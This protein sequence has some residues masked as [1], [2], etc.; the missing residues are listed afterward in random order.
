MTLS[1]TYWSK[2]TNMAS[3]YKGEV[4][5][6][7]NR[8]SP[9]ERTRLRNFVDRNWMRS[10]SPTEYLV[11]IFVFDRTISWGKSSERIT[12]NEFEK[13]RKNTFCGT[14]LSRSTLIRTLKNLVYL[15]T[16]VV[17]GV[18][19][20]PKKYA[21]N[22][23]WRPEENP[24]LPPRKA[25]KRTNVEQK[26]TN[27]TPHR[28]QND[29]QQGVSMTPLISR[30]YKKTN[31]ELERASP[32][33]SL[34]QPKKTVSK[35]SGRAC[36]IKEAI[37]KTE[38]SNAEKI[39]KRVLKARQSDN[40]DDVQKVWAHEFTNQWEDAPVIPWSPKTRGL[41]HHAVK[42]KAF[43]SIDVSE[44]V[45]WVIVDWGLLRETA[46]HWMKDMPLSPDPELFM[47]HIYKFLTA[48]S[49]RI[50][51]RQ[52][53]DVAGSKRMRMRLQ[54]QGLTADQA[55]AK[56]IRNRERV[57]NLQRDEDNLVAREK[58]LL[59]EKAILQRQ[60]RNLQA[61]QNMKGTKPLANNSEPAK[62]ETPQLK[63]LPKLD[64]D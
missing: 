32:S 2:W 55:D 14:G 56:L 64:F 38:A 60:Q 43:R 58:Q 61:R 26:G 53:F 47:T 41:Y 52:E 35:V 46:F 22:I 44:F 6:P 30:Q 37:A 42:N 25:S 33:G 9:S 12:F 1:L 5:L 57:G 3:P 62:G 24:M 34:P 36:T 59:R 15:G 28:C 18:H 11:V 4:T 45:T 16:L 8:L 50:T 63:P 49:K 23:A 29:T 51:L 39:A 40:V 17:T 54:R 21:I 7:D 48:Y 31:Y 10:L 27:W 13:G 19:G 20:K